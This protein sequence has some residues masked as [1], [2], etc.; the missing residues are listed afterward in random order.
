MPASARLI[1]G[2]LS[3]LPA[4]ALLTPGVAQELT[5]RTLI[6]VPDLDPAHL[7]D[8]DEA[9][10]AANIYSQ[11]LKPDSKT[12]D[13]RPDLATDWS[14][15]P[16][17]LT[18]TFHLRKDAV[19]QKGYGP[20]TADDV[21][22]TLERIR[23]PATHSPYKGD[24][25]NVDHVDAV[26]P[27]TVK[28][29]MDKPDMAFIR[30]VIAYRA[31]YVVS[32]KAM[33]ALGSKFKSSPVGSGPF[34]FESYRPGTETTLVAN[35][36]Y[37]L[38]PPAVKRVHFVVAKDDNVALMAED[39]GQMDI[40]VLPSFSS[41]ELLEQSAAVR[42][43]KV[44]YTINPELVVSFLQ[45]NNCKKPFDDARV[46]Q[47]IQHAINKDDLI[48]VAYG[49]KVQ[50]ARSVLPPQTMGY[51]GDVTE[52]GYDP[53]KA[54]A[55]LAE[56]GYPNGLSLNF[57]KYNGAS[58][59]EDYAPVL[60]QQLQKIGVTMNIL[61]L[62]RATVEERLSKGN[63]DLYAGVA[64]RPPD[65]DIELSSFFGSAAIPNPNSSCYRNSQVD[66]L[67]GRGRAEIDAAKR[68]GIYRQIQQIIA[69]DSPVVPISYRSSIVVIRSGISGYAFNS[70]V[71][72]DLSHVKVKN[73]S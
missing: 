28:I 52:Y 21:K 63:Y 47:A 13:P 1:A 20:V 16:D 17:G 68:I 30:K 56:A 22:F 11:L 42:S 65:P 73:G 4:S 57:L 53:S 59:W 61:G 39:A 5:V 58:P 71:R 55:L 3:L 18:Y 27:Y 6:D 49:G 67:I 15:S 12:L 46:R 54:Q 8:P 69:K 32:R 45:F 10:I 33:E 44:E 36:T 19:F 62:D 34:S 25:A 70:L 40:Q 23:E 37:F 43:G 7:K 14:L 9:A 64:G 29:V 31:G 26:D 66:E 2:A 50:K 48:E 35:S 60:Q 38:G 72:Y 24:M 51:D 41:I